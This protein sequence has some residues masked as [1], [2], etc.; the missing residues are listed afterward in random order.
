MANVGKS[1]KGESFAQNGSTQMLYNV[2]KSW[3]VGW[4][5]HYTEYTR[6]QIYKTYNMRRG[7]H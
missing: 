6:N 5:V 2:T 7:N 4:V 1:A 3:V